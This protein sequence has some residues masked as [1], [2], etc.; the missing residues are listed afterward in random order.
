M[1]TLQL[2]KMVRLEKSNVDGVVK[3]LHPLRC[4]IFYLIT[5]YI[6]TQRSS[7]GCCTNFHLIKQQENVAFLQA[8]T[9]LY[10]SIYKFNEKLHDAR[11]TCS[12]ELPPIALSS[13]FNA[14]RSYV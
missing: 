2:P 5:T 7:L 12:S 4:C 13:R 14:N 3:T 11:Q 1:H 6:S 8:V 9:K 10:N